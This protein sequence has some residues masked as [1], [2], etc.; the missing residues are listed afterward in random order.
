[1][2]SP[3]ARAPAGCGEACPIAKNI[4][5]FQALRRIDIE[6]PSLRNKGALDMN[7]MLV[8]FLFPDSEGHRKITSAMFLP[9]KQYYHLLPSCLH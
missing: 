9:G 5:A 7:E 6:S 4:L 2:R 8:D 3:A 1:M